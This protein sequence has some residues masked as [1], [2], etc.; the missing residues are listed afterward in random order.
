M[1]SMYVEHCETNNKAETSPLHKWIQ[2]KFRVILHTQPDPMN[3][4]VIECSDFN[5]QPHFIIISR[6]VCCLLMFLY[7]CDWFFRVVA[8]DGIRMA[9]QQTSDIMRLIQMIDYNMSECRESERIG[10]SDETNENE[11]IM[12]C[13]VV[14]F[15][16]KLQIH[17][18][19]RHLIP[20][21]MILN[22]MIMRK[23]NPCHIRSSTTHTIPA[24]VQ[25]NYHIPYT[26]RTYVFGSQNRTY[27]MYEGLKL[28]ENWVECR[29][30]WRN[31]VAR[32]CLRHTIFEDDNHGW[33]VFDL[34]ERF[35]P[36]Q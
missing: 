3:Q 15:K 11:K 8:N 20:F 10:W 13:R 7:D 34:R 2:N 29:R 28:R 17:W 21:E 30:G 19:Y 14:R 33:L 1:F 5:T 4:Q 9:L 24:S 6:L 27:M 22:W 35:V 31:D 23:M 26:I 32:R 18:T 36:C 25:L 12:W 16:Q